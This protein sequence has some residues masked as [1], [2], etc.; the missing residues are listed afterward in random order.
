MRRPEGSI[1]EIYLHRAPIDMRKQMNGLAA[2][3][4][5]V[6]QL[7]PFSGSLFVFINKRRDKLKMLL[8]DRSGFI[9]WYKRLEREKFCWPQRTT[10][11]VITLSNEQLHW[12]LDGYD[13]FRMQPHKTLH[14]L[15]VS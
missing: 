1:K 5:G 10:D 15:H 6:M 3:V 7:S 13:V 9:V 4:E 12:L 2:L 8:W 11:T 14:F